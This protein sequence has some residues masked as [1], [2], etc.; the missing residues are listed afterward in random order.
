MWRR[1]LARGF[2]QPPMRKDKEMRQK[3]WQYAGVYAGFVA[4]VFMAYKGYQTFQDP[5]KLK[6]ERAK[7]IAAIARSK[8]EYTGVPRELPRAELLKKMR[9]SLVV[10]YHPD[11]A[12]KS[13]FVKY[14][15]A[16]SDRPVLV[17]EGKPGFMDTLNQ[18]PLLHP[19]G[20]LHPAKFNISTF[21]EMLST[22]LSQLDPQR[23]ILIID[24]T[25]KMQEVVAR[26]L[27]M[28][29]YRLKRTYLGDAVVVT[30]S[31]NVVTMAKSCES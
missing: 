30:S 22:G 14:F 2:A 20:T 27:C 16:V 24:D 26:K 29:G 23:P 28:L 6:S 18:F 13:Q 8:P 10:V 21:Q 4:C 17:V 15:K 19:A 1:A 5:P 12:G 7:E 31:M 9:E 3:L 11:V 25:E